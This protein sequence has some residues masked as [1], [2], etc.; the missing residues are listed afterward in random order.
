[1]TV[2]WLRLLIAVEKYGGVTKAAAALHVSHS[3]ISHQLQLLQKEFG[4]KLYGRVG[5]GI[6]LTDVG[7]K[8]AKGSQSI[9]KQFDGLMNNLRISL[10]DNRQERLIVGAGYG[11]SETLLSALLAEY[12][13]NRPMTEVILRT[14]SGRAIERLVL[15]SQVEI[16][17]ITFIP[18]SLQLVAEPFSKHE[19]VPFASGNHPLARRS[20]VTLAELARTPITLRQG[21]ESKE[22]IEQRFRKLLG[23]RLKPNIIMRCESSEAVKSAVETGTS[24]GLLSRLRVSAGVDQGKFKILRA[25][26]FA[27]WLRRFIIYRKDRPMSPGTRDF[28]SLLR[29]QSPM[30]KELG[31][32]SQRHFRTRSV[33]PT[34]VR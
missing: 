2:N 5:Q 4:G 7:R 27:M 34:R 6:E 19:V 23:P 32:T 11:W 9:V 17:F 15:R 29:A 26:G 22:D 24:V 28:I 18:T 13:K 1:M 33:E 3:S 10:T 16:G 21:N 12:R 14:G 20:K 25:P 30:P 31:G 8:F